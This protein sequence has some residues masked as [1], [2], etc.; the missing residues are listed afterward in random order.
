MKKNVTS[1]T[2]SSKSKQTVKSTD[3]QKSIKQSRSDHSNLSKIQTTLNENHEN[4][5]SR[6]ESIKDET[7]KKAQCSNIQY[8][9]CNSTTSLVYNTIDCNLNDCISNDNLFNIKNLGQCEKK[10]FENAEKNSLKSCH[11]VVNNIIHNSCGEIKNYFENVQPLPIDN[12]FYAEIKQNTKNANSY[13]N[14]LTDSSVSECDTPSY[15]Q[16]LEKLSEQLNRLN[17]NDSND[18]ANSSAFSEFKDI[19]EK[20]AYYC[21]ECAAEDFCSEAESD[22]YNKNAT[23]NV[24]DKISISLSKSSSALNCQN[25]SPKK[26]LVGGFIIGPLGLSRGR[27]HWRQMIQRLGFPVCMWHRLVRPAPSLYVNII[28]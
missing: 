6:N 19:G 3:N 20:M 21:S 15:S 5:L 22:N 28:K 26:V 13:N 12:V 1:S 7:T 14:F 10:N 27:W 17:S 2:N 18:S 9:N 23:N 24:N 11:S 16:E 4:L 25:K 8:I